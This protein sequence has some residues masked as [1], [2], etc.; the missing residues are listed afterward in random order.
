MADQSPEPSDQPKPTTSR[1]G[2]WAGIAIGV[3]VVVVLLVVLVLVGFFLMGRG[4]VMNGRGGGGMMDDGM[5]MQDGEMPQWMMSRDGMGMQMMQDMQPIHNL[6]MNHEQIERQVE[7]IPGG[8]RSVTTSEDPEVAELI[9]KHVWQMKERVEQG[10]PIRMMDPVFREI[11]QH[12]QK[13]HMQV[14]EV[15]GGVRVTETSED[16]QVVKLIRQ[17]AHRAVTEFVEQGMPRAMRPTPLP[18]GYRD[19]N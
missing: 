5:M 1:R 18:D 16:P 11:F 15:P 8:I 3:G 17:H 14:E 4:C 10:Q 2:L 19:G 6:L 13:I 12:H 7:N 9:R